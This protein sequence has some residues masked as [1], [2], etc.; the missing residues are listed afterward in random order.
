MLPLEM[1]GVLGLLYVFFMVG[2]VKA[3]RAKSAVRRTA[4]IRQ[5]PLVMRI[6]REPANST[7]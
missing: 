2:T 1:I 4:K 6:A 3:L 5:K 7:V